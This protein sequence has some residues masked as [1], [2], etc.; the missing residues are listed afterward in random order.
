MPYPPNHLTG[1]CYTQPP[2]HMQMPKRS[3]HTSLKRPF[4]R[5]LK[6]ATQ[7]NTQPLTPEKWLAEGKAKNGAENGGSTATQNV[8]D[9]VPSSCSDLRFVGGDRGR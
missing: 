9:S 4:D 7:T 1:P 2:K 8:F 5:L 6:Q 3:T